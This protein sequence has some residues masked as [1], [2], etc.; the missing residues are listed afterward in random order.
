MRTSSARTSSLSRNTLE[1]RSDAANT[2]SSRE[3]SDECAGTSRRSR[4]AR[5]V[6]GRILSATRR[7]GIDIFAR[8]QAS[9]R[10]MSVKMLTSYTG[11]RRSHFTTVAPCA[12]VQFDVMCVGKLLASVKLDADGSALRI[13]RNQLQPIVSNARTNDNRPNLDTRSIDAFSEFHSKKFGV[14]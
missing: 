9:F 12:I 10:E 2:C 5:V 14:I 11:N 6:R 7:P 3:I 1:L 13:A 4:V 8:Q